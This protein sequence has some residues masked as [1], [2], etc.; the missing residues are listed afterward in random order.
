MLSIFK[1]RAKGAELGVA[2]FEHI[3][4]EWFAGEPKKLFPDGSPID[5]SSIRNEWLY[6]DAFERDFVTFLALGDSPEKD[7]VLGPFWKA[8]G[9]WLEGEEVGPL[10]E[11]KY[12]FSGE[13]KTIPAESSESSFRRLERRMAIY[14]EAAK[15]RHEYGSSW[16]VAQTFAGLC[17][18]QDL[19]FVMGVSSYVSEGQ[20]ARMKMIK[21]L[22]IEL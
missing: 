15:A 8:M 12:L 21:S 22:R 19:A 6:L 18:V 10:T 7:A 1:K 5:L 14:T 16:T 2:F 13:I 20:I 9:Q 11:R 3:Q 4:K 17:G